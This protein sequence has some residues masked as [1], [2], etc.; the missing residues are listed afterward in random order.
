[1]GKRVRQQ[2]V[3][4]IQRCLFFFFLKLLLSCSSPLI[5]GKKNST[6]GAHTHFKALSWYCAP[7]APRT[8]ERMLP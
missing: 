6:A 7:T 4:Q 3:L 8:R 2:P 1:M 5:G